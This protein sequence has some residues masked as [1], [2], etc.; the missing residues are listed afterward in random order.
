MLLSMCR[1]TH[2]LIQRL[3]LKTLAPYP[4][5]YLVRAQEGDLRYMA[6]FT[7]PAAAAEWCLTVQ[8]ASLYLPYPLEVLELSNCGV[9]LDGSGRLVFR[10]PRFKMGLCE[11]QPKCILPDHMGRADYHGPFVNQAARYADAAAHGGQIATD[12]QLANKIITHWHSTT[13]TAATAANPSEQ[14]TLISPQG[15]SLKPVVV[16]CS[17]LGS[18]LYKG[19]PQPIEM[20]CF[21]AADLAGRSYPAAAPGGKGMRLVQRVDVMDRVVVGLP[22][23]L[24][25]FRVI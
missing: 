9:Q 14:D 4:G 21:A 11:G 19:N 13:T 6:T 3:M 22:A 25:G 24:E 16:D 5:S 18:F 20:V 2:L 8:E 10:G 15:A 23:V 17:W 1:P 7:T 12:L